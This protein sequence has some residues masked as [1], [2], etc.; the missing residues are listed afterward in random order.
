MDDFAN[1]LGG[2]FIEM[3]VREHGLADEA[4][5]LNFPL[6]Q[7]PVEDPLLQAVT[8]CYVYRQNVEWSQLFNRQCVQI[9]EKYPHFRLRFMTLHT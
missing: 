1:T 9:F 4:Y 8:E 5:T 7:L 3:L 6:E 2:P